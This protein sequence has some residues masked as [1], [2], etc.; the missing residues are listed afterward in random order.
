MLRLDKIEEGACYLRDETKSYIAFQMLFHSSELF[1]NSHI[2]KDLD[3]VKILSD[4]AFSKNSTGLHELIKV[5]EN[6][7]GSTIDSIKIIICFENY[8]KAKLLLEGFIIHKMELNIC[9][10][11]YP[12]FLTDN[13]RQLKQRYEPVLIKD[14]FL[15]ENHNNLLQI[16]P[17]QLLTKHT[18]G[19]SDLLNQSKYQN[20]YLT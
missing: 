4:K 6:M 19:I 20:V 17:L 5:I 10:E 8:F 9:K 18:I 3:K 2:I 16:T 1:W 7:D 12:Q 14:I 13:G 15:A 11:K